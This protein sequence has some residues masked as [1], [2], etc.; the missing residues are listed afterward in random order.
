M[1]SKKALARENGESIDREWGPLF[2]EL[3]DEKMVAALVRKQQEMGQDFDAE[4]LDAILRFLKRYAHRKAF[5]FLR[6][7]PS[8]LL[9]LDKILRDTASREGKPLICRY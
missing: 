5:Y 3:V 2:S 8:E 4:N 6:N 1:V 9:S 7:N